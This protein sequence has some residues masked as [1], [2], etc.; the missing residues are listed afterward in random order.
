MCYEN[1]LRSLLIIYQQSLV[2]VTSRYFD[3]ILKLKNKLRV[4]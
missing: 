2:F 4:G 3:K 1:F